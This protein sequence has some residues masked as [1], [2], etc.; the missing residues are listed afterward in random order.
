MNR[1]NNYLLIIEGIKNV[2]LMIDVLLLFYIFF[3]FTKVKIINW[4]YF[5][6]CAVKYI[7]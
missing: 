2:K 5:I 4:F 7:E 6:Y 3:N 1:E